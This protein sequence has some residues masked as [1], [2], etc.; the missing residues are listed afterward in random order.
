MRRGA[1]RIAEK[2]VEKDRAGEVFVPPDRAINRQTKILRLRPQLRVQVN[3]DIS[4]ARAPTLFAR[5]Y[6]LGPLTAQLCVP[7]RHVVRVIMGG[8]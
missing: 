5:G 2:D 6:L 4:A 1:E 3:R 7:V 8:T